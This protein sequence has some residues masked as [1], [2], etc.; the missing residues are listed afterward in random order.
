MQARG[1]RL[2]YRPRA[3]MT[4]DLAA[5]VKAHKPA[6][7]AIVRESGPP[8]VL[9]QPEVRFRFTDGLM[10]FGDVCKGWTPAAW[11]AELRRKA[12]RCDHYRPDIAK[13]YRSW[14][15]DIEKRQERKDVR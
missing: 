2:R 3:R 6:L 14:A 11:A 8:E 10:E 5:R 15:A 12:D 13:Y 4:P 7:L 9:V 1:D